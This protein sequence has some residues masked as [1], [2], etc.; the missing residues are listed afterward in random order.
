MQEK[1]EKKSKKRFPWLRCFYFGI[2]LAAIHVGCRF[3]TYNNLIKFAQSQI[4]INFSLLFIVGV[5]GYTLMGAFFTFIFRL[6][7]G[8]LTRTDFIDYHP[9]DDLKKDKK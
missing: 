2:C 5:I 1:T 7:S 6:L 3:I 4:I 9:T 8:L